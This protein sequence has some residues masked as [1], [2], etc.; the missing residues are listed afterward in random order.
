MLRPA[1]G[2][3]AADLAELEGLTTEDLKAQ[4]RAAR[5]SR[6]EFAGVQCHKSGQYYCKINVRTE[7]VKSR[8]IGR[9]DAGNIL[10]AEL[11][12]CLKIIERGR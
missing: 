12:D 3:T 7:K 6:S 8:V 9:G 1:E 2:L 10:A 4:Q 11:F 5:V